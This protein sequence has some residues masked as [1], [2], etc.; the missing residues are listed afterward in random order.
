M[1][2]GEVGKDEK[3]AIHDAF[4]KAL[5]TDTM[6]GFALAKPHGYAGDFEII[7]RI[8]QGRMSGDPELVAWDRY[9]HQHA[10]PKAVRNRKLVLHRLLDELSARKPNARVLKIAVGP[11]RSMY[12]WLVANPESR[13]SFECLEIDPAAIDYA[14]RLNR[15]FLDRVHIRQG[16]A[17]R[18]RPKARYD[19]VWVAGLFDYFNDRTFVRMIRRLMPAVGE[20]GQLVIG[21][22]S[23][24][25]PSRAY[26]ELL[27]DWHLHHRSEDRL[28]T[29]AKEAGVEDDFYVVNGEPEK[30]NLFLRLSR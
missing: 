12:E 1:E 6:Q 25:N 30:V 18:I 19:L 7:D 2:R 4:G 27:G 24:S 28:Q 10:A 11:G 13:I 26:M 16:N 14:E 29:L 20:K 22:F 21:N 17:L 9:Y 3:G 23:N 5:S 8:Y 15:P